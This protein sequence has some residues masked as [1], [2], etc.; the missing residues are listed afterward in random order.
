MI[1]T[2]I[3]T[4]TTWTATAG[5]VSGT[6]KGP[7]SAAQ[8]LLRKVQQKRGQKARTRSRR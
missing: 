5:G 1:I 6:G 4:D 8:N 3:R 2:L 7:L